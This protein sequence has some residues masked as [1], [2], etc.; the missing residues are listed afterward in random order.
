MSSILKSRPDVRRSSVS[1]TSAK[2]VCPHFAHSSFRE[3]RS[4]AAIL[5]QSGT[6]IALLLSAQP[7]LLKTKG[8]LTLLLP[9]PEIAGGKIST[10]EKSYL[11]QKEI[12]LM[13]D[14][15]PI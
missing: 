11:L 1:E 3:Y 12:D 4:R 5:F 13:A 15:R 14:V 2:P 6:H 7:V 8:K 10:T 9:A